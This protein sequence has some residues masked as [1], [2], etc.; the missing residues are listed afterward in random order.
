M[1]PEV[2]GERRCTG[3][4]M[5]LRTRTGY[6]TNCTTH[7]AFC[8]CCLFLWVFWTTRTFSIIRNNIS[9]SIFFPFSSCP[10]AGR[11]HHL[12]TVW[13]RV[14][15][16]NSTVYLAVQWFK[17]NIISTQWT[18]WKEKTPYHLNKMMICTLVFPL[19]RSLIQ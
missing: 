15:N 8:L 1:Y 3:C 19:I 14:A 9:M 5:P 18:L 12:C 7:T 16:L 2:Y 10:V 13:I 4:Q 11:V 17:S 6:R